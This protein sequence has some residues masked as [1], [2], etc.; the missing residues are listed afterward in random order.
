MYKLFEAIGRIGV[1][2]VIALE[3]AEDAVPLA[4][5]SSLEVLIVPRLR[6][7][8]QRRQRRYAG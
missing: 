6:S 5:A 8:R 4:R 3:R 2:P 7:A 1:L